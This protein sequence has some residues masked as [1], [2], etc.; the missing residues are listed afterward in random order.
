MKCIHLPGIF[1]A[2][3]LVAAG[4]G[5][6]SSSSTPGCQT[7][8]ASSIVFA[9]APAMLAAYSVHSGG[10][11]GTPAEVAGAASSFALAP[12]PTASFLYQPDVLTHS[13]LAYS[14]NSSTASATPVNGSPFSIGSNSQGA[15][16][17]AI[18]PGSQYLYASDV[19]GSIVGFGII[20]STGGLMELPSS[21]LATGGFPRALT[22]D[23]AGRFLYASDP[24][25]NVLGYAINSQ[26]GSLTPVPGSPFVLLTGAVPGSLAVEPL[27]NFLYVALTGLGKISVLAIDSNTGALNEI[28]ASPF[29]AGKKVQALVITPNHFLYA[30][31]ASDNTISGYNMNSG[32][33]SL[34]SLSGSPF[35]INVQPS[36]A[37]LSAFPGSLVTDR[38]GSVLW[39][40]APWAPAIATFGID[41]NSGVLNFQS[42]TSL[43]VSTPP[44]QV[45]VAFYQ[46]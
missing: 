28:P 20:A 34:S 12:S 24:Y 11:L 8:T 22:I 5:C 10:A 21:P 7:C 19:N 32:D 37:Y 3:L 9:S 38:A 2:L 30:L 18:T 46:P 15:Y 25:G 39:V 36:L 1:L 40:G 14:I 29:G 27:G 23:P 45:S 6:S 33:G 42:A 31:N 4:V 44:G 26:D 13:I 41:G 35:P 43:P 17:I 16:G